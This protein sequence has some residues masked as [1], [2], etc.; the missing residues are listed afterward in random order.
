MEEIFDGLLIIIP[1]DT[2]EDI[3]LFLEKLPKDYINEAPRKYKLM[4]K[5][6]KASR[7]DVLTLLISYGVEIPEDIL[8]V[9]RRNL[10]IAEFLLSKGA[11]LDLDDGRFLFEEILTGSIW[12]I[13]NRPITD[14]TI[15]YIN[16][17][18]L[19][20]ADYLKLCIMIKSSIKVI[21]LLIEKIT[22]TNDKYL[23][24]I[25]NNNSLNSLGKI[26][27]LTRLLNDCKLN[28][29]AEIDTIINVG[30]IRIEEAPSLYKECDAMFL[31]T[32]L[33]CF[34]AS[35]VESMK[36]EKPILTSDMGFAWTVCNNA[37]IYF[38]PM[39]A[40]DIAAKI[41][42]LFNSKLPFNIK[43]CAFVVK[44]EQNSNVIRLSFFIFQ[45]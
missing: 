24:L 20:K 43:F 36:M 23:K 1:Y 40:N 3:T 41:I 26:E 38:D 16:N 21:M 15:L 22:P 17:V 35:Y 9:A 8:L 14:I 32:L 42:E 33:E 18:D 30:P 27:I 12:S 25:I 29:N 19:T 10:E 2:I 28:I 13:F 6:V 39:D 31:P 37:A 44:T 45:R 4:Y 11:K 7:L 34:S 5:A